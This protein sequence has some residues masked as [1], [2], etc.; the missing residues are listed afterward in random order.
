MADKCPGIYCGRLKLENDT[1]SD[2]GACPRGYQVDE[3][4]CIPCTDTPTQYDWLYLGFMALMPLIGS[5]FFIDMVSKEQSFTKGQLILHFSA[6][7]EV[8]VSAI[9]TLFIYEPVFSFVIHSCQVKKLSDWY[10]LFHNPSPNYG[11]KLYCTQ[12]AVFPLQ[13]MVLVFYLLCIVSMMM[14][15]PCLNKIFLKKGKTAIYCS[16][17]FIPVLSLLHTVAGGLIYYSFPY[18]SVIISMISNAVH[19]SLKLDQSMKSLVLS[20]VKEMKNTVVI[21]GHWLL[22]AYG[23]I[24]LDQHL[25]FLAFVPF[26]A[27]F[28]II[29][30]K[31]TDPGEFHIREE[32]SS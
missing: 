8:V 32:R 27:I 5:W 2:C 12:E 23:I 17:Y 11:E 13:T 22:L 30:V 6:L 10:T 1:W 18:L 24:S 15:R 25:A 9:V 21:V 3:S 7:M 14:I 26:P 4:R 16:L 28:Y 19:F 31:F 29:T 20:S